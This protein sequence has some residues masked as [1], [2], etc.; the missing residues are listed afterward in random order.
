MSDGEVRIREC[1][2]RDCEAISNLIGELAEME[3]L[4]HLNHAT[5][6]RVFKDRFVT[7]PPLFHCLLAEIE[8]KC[9]QSCSIVGYA[10][11]I[12]GFSL[13]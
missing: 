8:D 3:R 7:S 13:R 2:S 9:G 4:S 12:C 11:Y 10:L 6:D 5:G 1:Q